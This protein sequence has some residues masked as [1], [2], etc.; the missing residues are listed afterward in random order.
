MVGYSKFRHNFGGNKNEISLASE[1]LNKGGNDPHPS[2]KLSLL[3]HLKKLKYLFE[4]LK[5]LNL[6][7]TPY[8]TLFNSYKS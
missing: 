8:L 2:A 4:I 7:T 5:L 3:W 1:Y 6:P